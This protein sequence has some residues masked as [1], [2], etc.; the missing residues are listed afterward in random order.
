M[1]LNQV[2][3]KGLNNKI[4]CDFNFNED[5]NIVTGINGSGKTAFLKII[6]YVI[7]GNIHRITPEINFD[8]FHL[9]T[10]LYS[11]TLNKTEDII[12]WV[13]N[14][15]YFSEK[16]SFNIKNFYYEETEAVNNLIIKAQTSS[17]FFPT[18]RIIEGGYSMTNIR[19]VKTRSLEGGVRYITE[20]DE[21][22]N[23]FNRLS[24]RLSKISH[25]FI[26]SISTNNIKSLVNSRYTRVSEEVNEYSEKL[27]TSILQQIEG[28]KS[29]DN[30]EEAF[31]ILGQIQ[32]EADDFKRKT[33]ELFKPFTALS[34]L[35][36]D[37][38]QNK[39]IQLLTTLTIGQS[40]DAI[41]SDILSA[42]EKQMLSF[43]CYNAFYENSVIFIDEPE[44]SLHP[45]WQRR[46]FPILLK[47][48]ATNQFVVA[49][50]SP[51]IYSK[52]EDK[53]LVMSQEKG[54]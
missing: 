3:I 23:E 15:N 39:G 7:S 50:H 47:Q 2:S 18:F 31:T 10:N 11:I 1:K 29:R 27:T 36:E 51:F 32:K 52:Y 34:E 49:T 35:G 43:L 45:D 25:K 44:L 13:Y 20:D 48:Q 16:G 37:I 4:N 5:I 53:E 8:S 26:C 28:V 41:D 30:K 6:W 14:N 22:H 33:Q 12:Q 38:F 54:T 24:N 21:I 19:M 46:L 17:L 40:V 9:K 42:G